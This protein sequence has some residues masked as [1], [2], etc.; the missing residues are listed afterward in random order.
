MISQF[1][2]VSRSTFIVTCV[3]LTHQWHVLFSFAFDLSSLQ[4][5][6]IDF[7]CYLRG[8]NASVA[9]LALFSIDFSLTVV[10]NVRALS[11][12]FSPSCWLIVVLFSATNVPVRMFN[13]PICNVPV[14]MFRFASKNVPVCNVPVRMFRFVFY[15]PQLWGIF[16]PAAISRV[17]R[18]I[19]PLALSPMSLT[20][21]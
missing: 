4:R 12:P 11:G 3:V 9:C 10:V 8:F 6:W 21:M 17:T 16:S 1:F 13:V 15:A 14:R 18:S 19:L 5:E 2:S 7:C 20:N